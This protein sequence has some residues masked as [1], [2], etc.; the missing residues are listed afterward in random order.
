[1]NTLGS[2]LVIYIALLSL[3]SFQ[4]KPDPQPAD[5]VYPLLD[6]ANSRWFYFS[7]ATRPFGMVNL[8]PD[9]EI[10]G[11]WN[12]GYRYDA[13]SIKGFS[14]IHAWQM[15]GVSVMPLSYTDAPE[16]LLNDYYSTY[17]HD[18]ETIRVGYHQVYLDRFDIEAEL[19]ATHR[20]G[21]HR[22]H[23]PSGKQTGVLFHLGGTLG[24]SAML[25]GRLKKLGDR[26]LVGSVTNAPTSRR[27]KPITVHFQVAFDQDIAN[28]VEH[29]DSHH[30]IAG[31]GD[32]GGKPLQMKVSISYTHPDNALENMQQELPHW[33]FEQV[34]L[35]TREVWNEMLG[36]IQIEGNTEVQRRRFYTDLWKALQGRRTI[37]DANGA[38]PDHTGSSFRIGQVPLDE[39]GNPVFRHFNSDSFWGAQWTISVLWALVYPDIAEEFAN[40][41]LQYYLDGGLIPRGPS[42]GN[43]TNVMTGAS[44]TPFFVG[45]Y[46]KG[47][48]GFDV[49][50]AYQGLKKNHLPGG[51]MGRSGYEHLSAKGGNV[52]DY[53]D[54]GYVPYPNPR[55]RFGGHEQGAGQTL[56]Y[57][58]QDWT[59][60]QLAKALS[61]KEDAARF[62]A[63]SKN[64]K[65]V[66]DPESGWMRPKNEQGEWMDPFD[67]YEY[68]KGFVE[69]NAAQF[70][71]FV[72]H[73]LPG[74]AQLMGGK[75]KAVEKLQEQFL[76]AEKLGFTSG[77]SHAVETN[78]EYRRI[79]VNYGNQPSM[80]MA[81]IFNYLDRPDLTQYWSRKVLDKAFS[82]LTPHLGY[83][84]DEDQ[85]LMGSLAVLMKLGL[86][87]MNG[88]TEV[89]PIYELGSPIFDKAV[90]RLHPN[91]YPGKTLTIWAENNG[92]DHFYIQRKRFNGKLFQGMGVR[93]EDLVNGGV[94]RLQMSENP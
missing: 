68:G 91:Y 43:Y 56:E 37:S 87:Q 84:G 86:F 78:P 89:N 69:A 35:E 67:P 58:F 85:G 53:I 10:D 12:S 15:S 23:F 72:P 81:Y 66:Y 40:S 22:Y 21:M 79:P 46:Q 75:E 42:G 1:M 47:I 71:W 59:L 60:S 18:K 83:N 13:D 61:K 77:T 41:F 9:H 63:R 39:A 49:E 3:F 92:P 34:E 28:W 51:I 74:L 20:V 30:I 48:R 14:H 45:L 90:I 33:D 5:M 25:D 6:A 76:A 44:S 88:G 29:P 62:L 24:P 31:F 17:S 16:D 4:L 65:N 82:A 7:S 26:T 52:E 8:S 11:A 27:P 64:Y 54:K 36:R 94:L 32:L 93:H 2:R 50:T 80:Q 38:Y 19:T 55:G 73:D 57:S 70:T